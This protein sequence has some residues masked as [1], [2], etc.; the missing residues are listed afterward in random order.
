MALGIR[1]RGILP[2]GGTILGSVRP[3]RSRS[4]AASSRSAKPARARRRRP[5][6]DRR[7]GH[8][9]RRRPSWPTSGSPSSACRRPSTTTCPPPTSPSASTPPSTSPR[10]AIDRLHTTAESHH[11]VLVVEVM[12]RHAGW[13]AL[14][15]GIAGG[16]DVDPD[17]RGAVRHRRGLRPRRTAV[18]DAATRRS[19]SWPREPRRRED[20]RCLVDGGVDAFGHV[21]LGG[22]GER[23]AR[24]DRAAHRRR[25]PD[26]RARP[27]PARRHADRVRPG[28]GDPIRPA[29]RRRG[30]R[31]RLG[32][33]GS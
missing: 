30:P 19:S 22:I 24:R 17:P 33:D 12:G 28:T 27:H 32:E 1:R 13:I 20:G 18:R 8:A 14:H 6:R 16:A 11:R 15:A 2:R 21:A 10:E 26:D 4:T 3:T 7:R 9:R 5:D 31:R 23:L 25:G 29:R